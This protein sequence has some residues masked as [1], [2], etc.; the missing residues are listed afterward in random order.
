MFHPS[1]PVQWSGDTNVNG[2]KSLMRTAFV[3]RHEKFL[4]NSTAVLL[5]VSVKTYISA[6]TKSGKLNISWQ[7]HITYLSY[8][9]YA[10]LW[11]QVIND[12]F[13]CEKI[14]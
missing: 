12:D 2:L 4:H 8:K 7:I 3:E 1:L 10:A 11:S 9:A 13:S 5:L 14:M 6:T